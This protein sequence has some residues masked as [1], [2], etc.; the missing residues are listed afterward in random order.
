MLNDELSGIFPYTPAGLAPGLLN[1]GVVVPTS[2]L[3]NVEMSLVKSGGY[4][5]VLKILDISGIYQVNRTLG[6]TDDK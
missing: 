1:L 5:I 3:H 2:I 6:E 4:L